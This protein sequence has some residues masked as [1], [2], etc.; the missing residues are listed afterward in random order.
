MLYEV[1]SCNM[2]KCFY[3]PPIMVDY[4]KK[5]PVVNH[6]FYI[7][8]HPKMNIYLEIFGYIGTAFVIVSMMMT[9]VLKLRIFNMCGALISLIYAVCVNAWPVAVLNACLLC[10]NFVQTVRALKKREAITIVST[11]ADDPTAKHLF[12]VWRSDFEKIHLALDFV[13]MRDE[14]IHIL[15][16]GE[17]AVGFSVAANGGE[18][19]SNYITY[20]T[21]TH[22]AS[23]SQAHLT[24]RLAKHLD[25]IGDRK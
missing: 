10:I 5:I 14:K 24:E 3:K 15:Y 4:R 21:P 22:R 13:A 12:D 20:V 19:C 18:E 7:G 17:S 23:V 25:Q 1:Y 11:K 2:G 6:I 8:E 9:S 16:V